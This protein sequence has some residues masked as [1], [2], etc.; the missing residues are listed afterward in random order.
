MKIALATVAV[1]AFCASAHAADRFPP[2]TPEKMTP[3]QKT[4]AGAIMTTRGSM[5]GPF[6]AW[7]RDPAL[8]DRLERTGEQIRFHSSL[9]HALNEFA[10]L[11]TARKWTAQ[12]EWYAHYPLAMKAGLEPAVADD[13]AVGVRPRA[14]SD[15]EA[16]V[17]DFSMA[18]H[19]SGIVDDDLYARAVAKFGE[20]GV[21]DLIAVNGYYDLVSM[22][23]GVARVGL[24]D[25]VAPPLKPLS[26]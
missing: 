26:Q 25:G 2:I 21:I 16:I 5:N 18:L 7:L 6:Y 17:Y 1:L 22:T 15:E 4:I 12:F 20:Q 9:P 19:R 14:M 10:I 24:P 23:L 3:E 11:I 13:L 8:A